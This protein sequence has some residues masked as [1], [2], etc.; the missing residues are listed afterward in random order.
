MLPPPREESSADRVHQDFDHLPEAPFRPARTSIRR[1]PLALR[2]ISEYVA[3]SG[4]QMP[5]P[6]YPSPCPARR[7]Q[8]GALDHEGFF[9]MGQGSPAKV[10][11]DRSLLIV[12]LVHV[13]GTGP[14]KAV[15]K[16]IV[17]RLEISAFC[18]NRI[19]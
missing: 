5:V 1:A 15:P 17:N 6:G 4:P 18:C 7:F 9:G 3:G 16:M 11:A 8:P 12:T 10:S 13:A 19:S 2:R 14:S